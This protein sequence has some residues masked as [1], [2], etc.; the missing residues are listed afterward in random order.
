M[1]VNQNI[2]DIGKIPPQAIDMEEALLGAL[3]IDPSCT[4][5]VIAIV[6][7][8]SFYKDVHQKIFSAIV[9][10]KEKHQPVDILT[11]TG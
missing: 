8:Q 5:N 7:P 1:N 6:K 11:V 4:D 2:S 9:N 3:L 10:L